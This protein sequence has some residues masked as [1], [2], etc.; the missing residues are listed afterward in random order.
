MHGVRHPVVQSEDSPDG[1]VGPAPARAPGPAPVQ[2][3]QVEARLGVLLAG[4]SGALRL[5]H[6]LP[7]AEGRVVPQLP[8]QGHQDGVQVA[9][10]LAVVPEQVDGLLVPQD[11]SIEENK[12]S[13]N[14]VLSTLVKER[15]QIGEETVGRVSSDDVAIVIVER[16]GVNIVTMMTTLTRSTWLR[17]SPHISL[18]MDP[19]SDRVTPSTPYLAQLLLPSKRVLIF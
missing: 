13:Q 4:W 10:E 19:D 15:S 5:V 12:S 14:V 7:V 9:R 11:G 3:G 17:I 2:V 1:N 6:D 18:N 16:T 8:H